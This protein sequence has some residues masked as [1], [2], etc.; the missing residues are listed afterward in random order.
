MRLS[1]SVKRSNG[2]LWWNITRRPGYRALRF[3]G[4]GAPGPLNVL[5]LY[6]RHRRDWE[7]RSMCIHGEQRPD[8]QVTPPRPSPT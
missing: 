7:T 5:R 6:L 2:R 1:V 3:E 8:S 4:W